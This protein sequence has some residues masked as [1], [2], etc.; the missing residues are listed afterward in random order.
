MIFSSIPKTLDDISPFHY[1]F[2]I[3]ALLMTSVALMIASMD[4]YIPALPYLREE[5]DTTEWMMQFSIMIHPLVSAIVGI[6][7]G[8]WSDVHGRRKILL[9][10]LV[11]LTVGSACCALSTNLTTFLIS[12]F[13]Q[14]LGTGGM[15]VVALAIFADMFKGVEYARYM[16]A[17][18]AMF[19]VV[20]ALAPLTGAELLSNFGWHSNF[21]FITILTGTITLVFYRILPETTEPK[22][23][24]DLD[25]LFPRIKTLLKNRF[26]TVMGTAHSMPVVISVIFT[27][28]AAFLFIDTFHFTPVQYSY[29]ILLP[30][31]VNFI[32]SITYRQVVAKVGVYH[33]IRIGI[34]FLAAF[35]A[36]AA[37][38]LIYKNGYSPTL[39]L[40]AACL[41]NFGLTWIVAPCATQAFEAVPDDKGLGVAIV[42][43]IRNG[44]VGLI[45]LFSALFFDG[46]IFPVFSSMML[47]SALVIA[48]LSR[49]VSKEKLDQEEISLR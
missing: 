24:R 45:V 32:G 10:S 7:Y 22:K 42:S 1:R 17:Y 35:M 44:L 25:A 23:G 41:F 19:P 28:N 48:A 34:V 46:T 29:L 16:G 2:L 8:R 21:W 5:F 9:F 27:T 36:C 38:A 43:V 18:G 15:S 13:I 11:A 49:E 33:A 26:Y 39:I 12:R 31:A 40:A 30:I 3:P 14:A 37:W 47:L 4:I 20:F 6:I